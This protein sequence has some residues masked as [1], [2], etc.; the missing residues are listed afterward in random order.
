VKCCR[1]PSVSRHYSFFQSESIADENSFGERCFPARPD[2]AL[3][4]WRPAALF[5]ALRPRPQT[6]TVFSHWKRVSETRVLSQ[7]ELVGKAREGFNRA[8]LVRDNKMGKCQTSYWSRAWRREETEW[9]FYY[10]GG[11]QIG[12][13]GFRENHCRNESQRRRNLFWLRFH[14]QR[15]QHSP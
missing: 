15:V 11:G 3:L 14:S 13:R 10:G 8:V 12:W 6:E 9:L 4:G 1:V 2:C 5:P 7:P